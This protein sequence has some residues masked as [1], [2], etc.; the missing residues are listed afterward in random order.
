MGILQGKRILVTGASGKVGIP[1][2]ERLMRDDNEVWGIARFT[3][4]ARK[5]R[6]DD[7]GVHT[8]MVDL[9]DPDFSELPDNLDHVI[10]LGGD[11]CQGDETGIFMPNGASFHLANQVNGVG[12]GKLMS[13]FRHVESCLVV[14]TT[15]VFKKRD[16]DKY[17]QPEVEDGLLGP[18]HDDAPQYSASKNAQE[19]VARFCA[20]E[21][22]LPTTIARLGC[23]VSDV[24]SGLA[25]GYVGAIAAGMPFP[26]FHADRPCVYQY[27]HDDDIYGHLP[28]LLAIASTKPE[29]L[30]WTGA[31]VVD[32]R[33]VANYIGKRIGQENIEFVEDPWG[34][35][36]TISDTSR[37]IE[38]VG[39]CKVDWQESMDR[40]V[41]E[42][43][44]ECPRL[45]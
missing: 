31:E 34:L 10:H 16:A 33:D 18:F 14:S 29:T 21:F 1:M 8:Q 37:L 24:D 36:C 15:G 12:T 42:L 40:V 25:A 11:V 28:G 2:C 7:M 44:P 23:Q 13:R 39:P 19:V 41:D 35:M 3:D 5:K 6:L 17:D 26:G 32:I 9:L 20:E 45:G 30:N 22:G 4:P 27:I 43:M 38:L